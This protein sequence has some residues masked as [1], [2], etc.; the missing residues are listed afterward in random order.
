M[1][2]SSQQEQD[3]ITWQT[4]GLRLGAR[5]LDLRR[6]SEQ[7][8]LVNNLNAR[9][10]DERTLERRNGHTGVALRDGY[11]YPSYD[12]NDLFVPT[13][14]QRGGWVY[15][16]G[17]RASANDQISEDA[18]MPIAGIAR[19]TFR[20]RGTDVV[21]T[22]DRLLIA[23][24]EGPAL[25]RSTYWTV[26]TNE[27]AFYESIDLGVPAYL[28]VVTDSTPPASVTGSYVET[29]VTDIIRVVVSSASSGVDAWVINRET[30]GVIDHATIDAGTCSQVRVIASGSIPVCLYRLGG[31]LKMSYWTGVEWATPSVVHATV[32]TYDIALEGAGFH[33]LYRSGATLALLRYV[34]ATL[35]QAPYTANTAVSATGT[36][37]GSVAIAVTGDSKLGIAYASSSGLY[38]KI[39]T[40]A[41]IA[42]SGAAAQLSAS[43]TWDNGLS[44][45]SRALR[46]GDAYP[47]VV[48]AGRSDKVSTW[49]IRAYDPVNQILWTDA[50]FNSRM[51]SRLFLVGNEVFAWLRNT[52]S[53]THY[54]V[55]GSHAFRVSGFS[56]REVGTVRVTESGTQALQSVTV[57]PD[58]DCLFTWI[59]PFTT[60]RAVTVDG[61]KNVFA[62][63][64]A[65]AGNSLIGDIN[66]LPALSAVQYGR[67]VYL[68]GSSVRN[69]DG[70]EL[71]DTGFQSYPKVTA[72]A[73]AG[74]G[75]AL[76]A[77][78]YFYRVYAVRYNAVGERFQS[79]AVTS[80]AQVAVTNDKITLTIA[81][82]PDTSHSD[83]IFEVY[84]CEAGQTTFYLDGIVNNSLT[85]ATVS[86]DSSMSDASLRTQVPDPH[87]PGVG[88]TK[89]LQESGPI[90][91]AH[92]A[93]AGD[94]L[95]GAGG[96]VPAGWV[97][98]SK[99]HEQNEGAGFDSIAGA[100]EIDTQGGAI[101]SIIGFADSVVVFQA[102][103]VY[104]G[105]GGG[106]DN[107]GNGAFRTPQL[108]LAD[109]ATTNLG[110]AVIQIGVVFWGDEGP[111]LLDEAL[112]VQDI[113]LPIRD[114]SSDL[115]PT[116]VRVD[117]SRQEVIW[118][119][120]DGT[121]L[122]W[123]YMEKPWRWAQ[124]AGLNVA[125]CS[126]YALAT[127][128]GRLLYEGGGDDMGVPF[129]FA[130][131]VGDLAVEDIL[132]GAS[133][134]RGV[135]IVGEHEGEHRLRLRVYY[136][137]M[138]L[139]TDQ[140][141]W[142]PETNTWLESGDD[143]STLTPAQIDALATKDQ[144]GG[145]ATHKRT[146]R[147]A[148][149]TFRVEWSDVSAHNPTYTPHELTLELGARGGFGHVAV[150]TFTRS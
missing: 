5:G 84:R 54:L 36:P 109:G 29:C 17:Q 103:R 129:E 3:G 37:N 86:Y 108:V 7:G 63:S 96:Q 72:L 115:A 33:L 122:L 117:L 106:P 112:R 113:H 119:T 18:H 53:N 131:A 147:H 56:E 145:Y 138:D 87:A 75:G 27:D 98:F 91:C 77:G 49:E 41:A 58:G 83:V 2:R 121:A 57:D 15:G 125:G 32:D 95:W 60:T 40:A 31:D 120:E 24:G 144:S 1:Q 118:Y 11:P 126:Q 12:D 82:L 14:M 35:V 28:P 30:G 55:G 124:W 99:L 111:R 146:S 114:L 127:T 67:S 107:F 140:W 76:S 51:A 50:R 105:L 142:A 23:R 52:Q 43:T 136:N 90:G 79:V 78:T 70:V 139:W 92:L 10:R 66:F 85:A 8:T 38:V 44:I 101:T 13:G 39:L 61:V 16:H 25:G 65:H 71:G 97:Q 93:V 26:S 59:R 22:G 143:L 132:G 9:F 4:T 89:E 102:D 19:G 133:L 69:W 42:I 148:C 130:G 149:R 74:S 20:F 6:P 150:G 73:A 68:A 21:W 104:A 81:T 62:Q 88:I 34:G 80:S 134:L 123:N 47:F 135:G 116:G 45:I 141:V 137:G 110:T 46:H 94:R 128:D 100:Q 48:F 64:Y